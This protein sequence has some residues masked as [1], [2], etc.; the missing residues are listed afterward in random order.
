MRG[1]KNKKRKRY[2]IKEEAENKHQI[3][4]LSIEGRLVVKGAAIDTD[5]K[6]QKR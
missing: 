2:R 1:I 3:I 5:N 4:H 6:G